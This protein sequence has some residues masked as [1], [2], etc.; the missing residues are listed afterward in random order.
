ILTL[1]PDAG[2]SCVTATLGPGLTERLAAPSHEGGANGSPA[3]ATL[4]SRL[5]FDKAADWTRGKVLDWTAQHLGFRDLGRTA[6]L[7]MNYRAGAGLAE[8]LFSSGAAPPGQD[9]AR[10]AVVPVPPL[11]ALTSYTK[12]SKGPA[13]LAK[14][15]AGL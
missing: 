4:T 2:P 11:G 3:I 12:R 8:L 15:G 10:V 13:A 7:E 1:G 6:W 9:R 14:E 5:E